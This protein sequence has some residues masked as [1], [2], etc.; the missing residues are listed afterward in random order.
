M[1][2]SFSV[3]KG[4]TIPKSLHNIYNELVKESKIS[5]LV[6]VKIKPKT[7]DLTE[8]GRQGVFM[9]NSSL[10]VRKAKAGSHSKFGWMDFTQNTLKYLSDEY[11]GLVFMLWG[12]HAKKCGK[13][14]DKDKHFILESAHPSP[15]SAH[16]GFIGN[17]HFSKANQLLIEQGKA[18]INWNP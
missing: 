4:I 15:L 16:R 8:W 2:S 1:G 7:G 13:I 3:H 11:E 6:N 9:L 10:T 14:I 12:N 17:N 5:D 18:P